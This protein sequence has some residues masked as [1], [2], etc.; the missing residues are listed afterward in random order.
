[1][2]TILCVASY[3]KGQEFIR[4]CKR[5]G[6]RVLLLTGESLKQAAWPW[7]SI[8]EVHFRPDPEHE[9]NIEHLLLTISYIARF[10]KIERIVPLDDFD[11]EKPP[12]FAS[13]S[14]CPVWETL[15]PDTSETNWPCALALKK[16]ASRSPGSPGC[17]TT[18][19]SMRS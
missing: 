8:D 7:E 9:W 10:E 15:L 19:M 6:W 4:Q 3:E 16:L 1:M 17:S 2:G 18:A 12:C 13:T 11:V 5:E 14:G